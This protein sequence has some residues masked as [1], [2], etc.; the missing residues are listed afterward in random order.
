MHATI[1]AHTKISEATEQQRRRSQ[2]QKVKT[3]SRLNAKMFRFGKVSPRKRGVPGSREAGFA[4]AFSILLRLCACMAFAIRSKCHNL[5]PQIA[6]AIRIQT[7]AHESE[8]KLM[9]QRRS[10]RWHA[11]PSYPYIRVT[12]KLYTCVRTHAHA[13]LGGGWHLLRKAQAWSSRSIP[14]ARA[15]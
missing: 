13:K 9:L 4:R 10:T 3:C 7:H 11:I 14:L 12:C 2:S 15:R 8:F 6:R 5:G 1:N